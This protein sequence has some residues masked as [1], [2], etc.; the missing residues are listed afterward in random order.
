M[1]GCYQHYCSAFGP[2]NNTVK[3]N[4]S[5]AAR[6][7]YDLLVQGQHGTR[8]I[9]STIKDRWTAVINIAVSMY[10]ES[11]VAHKG[12]ITWCDLIGRFYCVK[13]QYHIQILALTCSNTNVRA[14]RREPTRRP[15]H[16]FNQRRS[17]H[18]GRYYHKYSVI[19]R[20]NDTWG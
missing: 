11:K 6:Q 13:H 4:H 10:S 18:Q 5:Q 19:W 14:V 2:I 16:T 20:E 17:I 8:F 3:F 1:E 9:H 12:K 7:T 15:F